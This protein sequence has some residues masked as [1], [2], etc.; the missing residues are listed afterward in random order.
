[1]NIQK[2]HTLEILKLL[3]SYMIVFIHVPFYGRMGIALNCLARFAVPL[4][5]LI[6]GYFAYQTPLDK[7]KKRTL[8]CLTL[9]IFSSSLY[10]ALKI[11]VHTLNGGASKAVSFLI[12]Y[13]DPSALVK[14]FVFNVTRSSVHLWYLMAILYVYIIYYFAMKFRV[15]E[16]VIFAVSIS[17]LFLHLLLGE[18]LSFFGRSLQVH[19]LRNFA[20]MGIPF[21]SLGLYVKKY[22]RKLCTVPNYLIVSSA[23]TGIFLTLLSRYFFSPNELY[24]GSLFILFAV[25]CIFIKFQSVKYPSFLVAFDGCSTFIYI[26]HI[27]VLY[28]ILKSCALLGFDVNASV[29]R[30]NLVPVATCIISTPI[31]YLLIRILKKLHRSKNN[32]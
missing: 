3:S 21:F 15:N 11:V 25:V 16:K 5:F 30:L 9:L 12:N 28:V 7:I 14:L 10:T 18:G 22:E 26:L 29:M 19:F 27:F 2:N 1:M 23:V 17:L 31:S 6:S 8:N 24:V 4:F 13:S 20:L 32:A